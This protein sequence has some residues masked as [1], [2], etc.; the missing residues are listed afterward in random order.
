MK[1]PRRTYYYKSKKRPSDQSLLPRMEQIC[2]DF[3]RYG[4][5]RVTKQLQ[6]EGRII[7]HKKVA[8]IMREK[9][10]RCRPRKRKWICTTDSNHNFKVYPNLIKDRAVDG[11]NQLWVADITYIHILVCFVYLAVILDVYSRK[12]IGYATPALNVLHHFHDCNLIIFVE[13][14]DDILFWHIIA[15]KAGL[16]GIKIE[17][18]GGIN[19][20]NKKIGQIVEE[21]AKIVVACDSDYS[22]FLDNVP[23]HP[24]IVRTYGYSIEN[25]MYCPGSL[26]RFLQKLSR[27]LINFDD[28]TKK[29]LSKF[30]SDAEVLILFDIANQRYKKGISVLGE[31]CS[32]FLKT[33]KSQA[34]SK[35]KISEFINSIKRY[36]KNEELQKCKEILKDDS[37]ELRQIIKGHFLTIGVINMIKKKVKEIKKRRLPLLSLEHL[38]T[39]TIDSCKACTAAECCE[40]NYMA[41]NLT[42]A[43]NTVLGDQQS[44]DR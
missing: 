42:N 14:D 4:Y 17:S 5:R 43:Y 41:A 9:G 35:E 21:S 7:N 23:N 33:K 27:Q 19:E 39:G 37:R 12:A 16:D 10:W 8:R 26:S 40:I 1:L 28:A 6:R 38:Y 25:T 3:P 44:T 18:L 34:L 31:N 32:N 15:E 2:L 24:Q 36:F 20:I 30:V 13:G 22:P 11:I 29:W